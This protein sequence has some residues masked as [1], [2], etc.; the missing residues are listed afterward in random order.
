MRRAPPLHAKAVLIRKPE[1]QQ[2]RWCAR[3]ANHN[4]G[5]SPDG[6][7]GLALE[8]WRSVA[9]ERLFEVGVAEA[10]P[11][12]MS[13]AAHVLRLAG[14][15]GRTAL[16]RCA[17]AVRGGWS[18][19]LRFS[20]TSRP[21]P[22]ALASRRLHVTGPSTAEAA[23]A[24][25][26]DSR[27]PDEEVE[28]EEEEKEAESSEAREPLEVD[29]LWMDGDALVDFARNLY[30]ID[31]KSPFFD[32]PNHPS[33]IAV[34][35][36]EP[37]EMD[38]FELEMT[39]TDLV[40]LHCYYVA[41]LRP[42]P[43]TGGKKK[44]EGEEEEEEGGEPT[45]A[46]ARVVGN[47][48][49]SLD[50]I[51]GFRGRGIGKQLLEYVEKQSIEDYDLPLMIG[52][53]REDQKPFFTHMGYEKRPDFDPSSPEFVKRKKQFVGFEIFGKKFGYDGLDVSVPDREI[54][55]RPAAYQ[56][57]DLEEGEEGEDEEDRPRRLP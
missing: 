1:R 14:S 3:G 51:E 27:K 24:A 7:N 49:R 13:R 26:P 9:V 5:T 32:F 41:R 56:G 40:P 16:K 48:L 8:H 33:G 10:D 35:P 39:L 34:W 53:P 46:C 36:E 12:A 4:S 30:E 15:A 45:V 11:D 23:R 43:K 38:D 57:V 2:L 47:I 55:W 42:K 29:V 6:Y 19:A 52:D 17:A 18:G 20:S 31:P 22:P 50:V 28:E 25:P 21:A 54:W 44:E 37:D